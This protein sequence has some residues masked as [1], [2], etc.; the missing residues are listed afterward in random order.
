METNLIKTNNKDIISFSPITLKEDYRKK[1]SVSN[2]DF[3]V[4]TDKNGNQVNNSLYRKGGLF[5]FN[6]TKDK[7]LMLLKQ[8]ESKYPRHIMEMSKGNNNPNHLKDIHCIVDCYGNEKFLA[9]N[10]LDYPY[11][12]NDSCLFKYKGQIHNIETLFC[13]GQYDT[14]IYTE[15]S[16]IV[17][18]RENYSSPKTV[19]KINK[20]T[21]EFEKID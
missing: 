10:G 15:K 4:L 14:C 9:E 20:I 1:F 13:Y 11:V 21:G 12:I 2:K 8:V 6:P 18:V 3:I 19:I 17:E 5:H 16:V 7:Y